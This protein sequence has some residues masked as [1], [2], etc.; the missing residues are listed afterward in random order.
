[1]K[2]IFSIVA[3]LTQCFVYGQI[4]DN[5]TDG[6]VTNNPSWGG[7]P[8]HFIVNGSGQA[9]LNNVQADTSYLSTAHGLSTMDDKEWRIWTRQ[10]FSPS[11]GNYAKIFLTAD[12]ADLTTLPD[13]FYLQLGE[14]GSSDA[15]H[16]IRRS[17]GTDVTLI[18]GVSGQIAS[19]FSIGIRVLRTSA[20]DWTLSIDATGGQNYVLAGTVNDPTALLGTHFGMLDVYTVS[21][22]TGFYYDDIYVGDEIVDTAPPNI[23]SATAISST[24]VDV[25]FDETLDPI[26]SQNVLNYSLLP[27]IAIST[28]VQDGVNAA[29]MHITTGSPLTNGQNYQLTVNNV[30]DIS[31]NAI[32]NGQV[33]FSYLIADVPQAGDVIIN[34]F[35][36]DPDPQ[37]G[38]PP[39][40]FVEIHNV[41][42]KIFDVSGW[43]LKDAASAGTLQQG[44]LLPGDHLVLTATAN[45]DSFLVATAV[46]SFP[47]LNNTGDNIVLVSDIGVQL[48]SITYTDDWYHDDTKTGGGWTIERINPDLVC[49][50]TDNWAASTNA[51][52]GTPGLVNAVFD[53]TADTQTPQLVELVALAPNYLEVHFNEGMDSTSLASALITTNPSLTEQNRYILETYPSM[54]T[55]QFVETFTASQL[56]TIQLN[57]VADCSQNQASLAGTFTLPDDAVPGDI[58]INEILFNPVTGGYDWVEV[59]NRTNKV[60]NLKDWQFANYDNDSIDNNKSITDQVLLFPDSYMVF[61]EDTSEAKMSFPTHEIGRF[62][63][64]DLPT[65]SNDSGTVYLIGIN[66]VMDKVSYSEDWHFQFLDD[67]DGKSLERMD[68]EGPSNDRNNWHTAAEAIGFGTPGL[69]NSQYYPPIENGDFN[70]TSETISPD[71]DG[72]E[73]VLQINYNMT[74]AGL[75]GDFTIYDDRGREIIKLLD[76]ELLGASGTFTWDGTLDDNSKATIGAYIGVFEV[77]KLDGSVAFA[78]RKVFVVAGKL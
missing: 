26:T 78:K 8:S 58:V 43:K 30:E 21:N 24:E 18:S 40:E 52:G 9:Q 49:S 76:S 32:S 62:Y 54:M 29:L 15:V 75:V 2:H 69:K 63:E 27:S 3:F 22:S 33:N 44:W 5:F 34:E 74:E 46:T 28:V 37:I 20:G 57:G 61:A 70:Y 38:L 41:S 71:N 51:N 50:S 48:D 19:S 45:V 42:A 10:S 53:N 47:S 55:L 39:V 65:Y 12:N 31:G 59:Y 17:G 23:V 4:T 68:P 36:C 73:D 67:F 11:G 14:A 13:G 1:M 7:T 56:Y 72:F 60:L 25:L 6:D 77:F 16:L 66:S 35:M 64:M